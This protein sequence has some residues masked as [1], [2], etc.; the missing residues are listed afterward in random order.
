MSEDQQ[1]KVTVDGDGSDP[2]AGKKGDL[3]LYGPDEL[4]AWKR[5][6]QFDDLPEEFK[7]YFT[8]LTDYIEP[9][10]KPEDHVARSRQDIDWAKTDFLD[11]LNFPSHAT[12][13]RNEQHVALTGTPQ[14]QAQVVIS[15]R[16]WDAWNH[17]VAGLIPG[18]VKKMFAAI[19]GSRR[20]K[21]NPWDGL[22]GWTS[23]DSLPVVEKRVRRGG[24][25]YVEAEEPGHVIYNALVKNEHYRPFRTSAGDARIAI[26]TN[27]GL[28]VF[29][30][31]SPG[32]DLSKEFMR[33]V[34]YGMFTLKGHA[35]P[36]RELFVAI[37]AL[38]SRA[39]SRDLPKERVVE[40]SIR[41]ASL[42]SVGS[43]LDLADDR[44]RCVV[45][46]PSGWRIEEIGHPV[47]D[48]R[49]H[50]LALPE[51]E[52]EGGWERI[53]AL[54]N[55]INLAPSEPGEDP[56]LL[57]ISLLVQFLL[58]PSEPKPVAVLTGD[59]GAGK[60]SAAR[61]FGSL[62][63]PSLVPLVR[64]PE[65][66]DALLNL[67]RNHAVIN[68]DNVSFIKHELSDDL[69]RLS[70]GIG[71]AKRRLFTDND[72]VVG[73][74]KP[75]LVMNGITAS[76]SAADLLR[77]VVFFP[78]A[79]PSV[80]RSTAEL[81][82]EWRMAHPK[83]LGGLLDLA[84]ETARV[85]SGGTEISAASSMADYVRVG[86]AVAIAMGRSSEDFL[87]AW[88]VNA[89]RQG[90]AA[91]ENPWVTA[92]YDF[93][94]QQPVE[95]EPK[96]ADAIAAFISENA[97]GS[98]P[99]GVTSQAVGNAIA[100][101]KKT[102]SRMGIHVV[103]RVVH[104]VPVYGRAA[105]AVKART[106]AIEQFEASSPAPNDVSRSAE[107]GGY[108]GENRF[109]QF[110]QGGSSGASLQDDRRASL[111]LESPGVNLG[112]PPLLGSPSLGEPEQGGSTWVHPQVHPTFTSG[113]PPQG[114]PGEP[115]SSKSQPTPSSST[116]AGLG[117]EK[118]PTAGLD[119]EWANPA[120]RECPECRPHR[121]GDDPLNCKCTRCSP[122]GVPTG[123]AGSH[124]GHG[125]APLRAHDP[126]RKGGN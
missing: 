26:P 58:F 82:A 45:I 97:R 81:D 61:R 87:A 104:G 62:I 120:C 75:L 74:A 121:E 80:V 10:A 3:R 51:P 101:A 55:F 117:E 123:T 102:L 110:T 93:F 49:R 37:G 39:M 72:E 20:K 48:A 92:L 91:S 29:D 83:I 126:S 86:Q 34:G 46:D 88:E 108:P 70:T 21:D 76:P 114:E 98:F 42:P 109:T 56:E 54:W 6:I 57:A 90:V 116:P 19:D 84:V 27:W 13:V 105:T 24:E 33:R 2:Y 67:A 71:L 44:H 7:E 9:S 36:N 52:R 41:I 28:E 96:R 25:E 15:A 119:E 8:R 94:N 64:P 85:L 124:V 14:R 63:D 111:S 66:E 17:R 60:S 112:E 38:V 50:M 115:F 73:S 107:P 106:A 43:R 68:I 23:E 79:A 30:P 78:I 77:R 89:T 35:V 118:I 53:G 59:E 65:D 31:L 1:E 5:A 113:D 22:D 32:G 122:W 100:R 11:W 125:C 16:I 12:R 103:R 18:T 69:A 47:F 95:G 4:P 40:L 99:K